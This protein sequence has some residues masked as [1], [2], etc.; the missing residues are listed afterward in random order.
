MGQ[1]RVRTERWLGLTAVAAGLGL[2]AVAL[3]ADLLSGSSAPGLGRRQILLAAAGI[4]LAVTG[5]LLLSPAARG[6][7]TA[8]SAATEPLPAAHMLLAALLFGLLAGLLEPA[9]LHGQRAVGLRFRYISPH[10]SWM[11]PI[12]YVGFL[13]LLSVA[14]ILIGRGKLAWLR[15]AQTTAALLTFATVMLLLMLFTPELHEAASALV[16]GGLAVQAGRVAG[17]R[18]DRLHRLARRGIPT[19]AALILLVTAYSVGGPWLSERRALGAL[20]EAPAGSPNVLLIILDTVRGANVSFNDYA[21]PTTP[22]LTERARRGVVF[23][24]ALVSAPWSLPSHSSIVT[25]MY[26]HD[27]SAD[28]QSALDEQYPT[29]GEVMTARGFQTAGFFANK[30][31]GGRFTGLPRGF[32]HWDTEVV[33]AGEILGA[34]MAGRLF[35]TPYRIQRQINNYNQAG[36]KRAHEVTAEFLGWVEGV[37]DRPF[38]AFLNYFD[39]HRPYDAPPPH[40]DKFV[41]T[42]RPEVPIKRLAVADSAAHW[43]DRYDG[44]IALL[45]AELERV[46]TELEQIGVL[47]NTLVIVTSDHGEAFSE[48]G[49][50]GHGS[51][52][53]HVLH[54]PLVMWLPGR[55]PEGVRVRDPVTLRDLAAT[56]LEFVPGEPGELPGS[57][58][59]RH[60]VRAPALADDSLDASEPGFGEPVYAG[61][62]GRH[63]LGDDADRVLAVFQ[64][65]LHYIRKSTG[66]EE[67]YDLAADPWEQRDVSEDPAYREDLLRLRKLIDPIGGRYM[68]ADDP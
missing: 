67:L 68:P 32:I 11:S 44:A 12:S 14:V 20:P 13:G 60:W 43:I 66:I 22:N 33:T 50:I 42:P 21:R 9:I 45:D 52:Y 8:W 56:I 47:E 53:R 64:D 48:T 59:S 63:W 10:M 18:P 2:I 24:L 40:G 16:A 46:F 19:I 38:F 29:I 15:S 61:V 7:L 35:I 34:S 51:L 28:W 39:A 41:G 30:G 23:E 3:L 27:L 54:V 37:G 65:E 31:Y 62:S 55:V 1:T 49:D 26:A 57:S 6:R 25:G 58:L 5:A 4:G 36:R 17:R